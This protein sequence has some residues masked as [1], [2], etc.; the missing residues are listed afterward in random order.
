M[1]T[2]ESI[3]EKIEELIDSLVEEHNRSGFLSAPDADRKADIIK[4]IAKLRASM[5]PQCNCQKK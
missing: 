5:S 4:Q 2:I 3:D 1:S